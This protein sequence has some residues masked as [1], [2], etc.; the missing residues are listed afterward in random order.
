MFLVILLIF[1]VFWLLGS[2]SPSV[3][4]TCDQQGKP[5]KWVEKEQDRYGYLVCEV[6]KMRPGGSIDQGDKNGNQS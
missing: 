5:H 6:C 1:I 3:S 4:Q 2:G